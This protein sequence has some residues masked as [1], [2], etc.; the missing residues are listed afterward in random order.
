M[1]V[2]RELASRN[3]KFLSFKFSR[4][5]Y[6]STSYI[7]SGH[8][9]VSRP[10]VNSSFINSR[11]SSGGLS[12]IDAPSGLARAHEL[13]PPVILIDLLSNLSAWETISRFQADPA[14]ADIPILLVHTQ[15]AFPLGPSA[16]VA[17]PA[18]RDELLAAWPASSAK[19][20]PTP[21]S[22]WTTT[23]ASVT[24]CAHLCMPRISPSSRARIL[25]WR[26]IGWRTMCRA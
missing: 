7:I 23:R 14:T 18:Q 21:S 25:P 22:S 9:G 26:G 4:I 16:C 5:L 19:R 24:C 15:N 6:A 10:I 17:R 3:M 13:H 1:K 8:A 2:S 11:A 12:V 20:R